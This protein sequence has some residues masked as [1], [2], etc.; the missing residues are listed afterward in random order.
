MMCKINTAK[1]GNAVNTTVLL[2]FR[3]N[4]STYC[5]KAH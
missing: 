1:N 2:V 3:L 5:R 4:N